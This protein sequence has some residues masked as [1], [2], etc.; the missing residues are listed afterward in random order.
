MSVSRITLDHCGSNCHQPKE[1]A[2]MARTLWSASVSVS[3]RPIVHFGDLHFGDLKGTRMN[4][5]ERRLDMV[6]Q[7][8]KVDGALWRS[9]TWKAD[10]FDFDLSDTIFLEYVRLQHA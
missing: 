4:A 8:A 5:D 2:S 7:C 10:C 1:I 6:A 3:P 9:P